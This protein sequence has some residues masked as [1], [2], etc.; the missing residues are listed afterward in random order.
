MVILPKA[1]CRFNTIP[2]RIPM[3]HF[4]GIDQKLLKYR[5]NNKPPHI[6]KVILVENK[7]G[8]ITFLSFKCIIKN[9]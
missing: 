9:I 2:V 3:T 5:G 8:Q 7:M 4:K 6:D 1:L